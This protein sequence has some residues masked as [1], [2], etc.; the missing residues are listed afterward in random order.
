[1][2]VVQLS[3][4]LVD[5]RQ[6]MPSNASECKPNSLPVKND[7]MRDQRTQSVVNNR[8]PAI[9]QRRTKLPSAADGLLCVI[10]GWVVW[11][12]GCN[13]YR[14]AAGLA[15]AQFKIF[16]FSDI[17]QWVRCLLVSQPV[18]TPFLGM[19]LLILW[20]ERHGRYHFLNTFCES[21]TQ[22]NLLIR[23]LENTDTCI[24]HSVIV[25]NGALCKLTWKIRTP[26]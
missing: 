18:L 3:P 26:W 7:A 15:T 21:V 24:I 5:R 1:M 10:S 8:P 22:Q 23:T 14:C 11:I 2:A 6:R 25:P 13:C 9:V 4:H 20:K 12:M 16:R 19:L 17:S